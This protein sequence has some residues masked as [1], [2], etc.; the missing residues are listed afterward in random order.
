MAGGLAAL[1][2]RLPFL[3]RAY[4]RWKHHS[5]VAALDSLLARA[6]LKENANSTFPDR[7]L[8]GLS[9]ASQRMACLASYLSIIFSGKS[10]DRF[11]K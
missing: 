9:L 6:I 1:P 4:F 10:E 2:A 8:S 7:A 11:S 5:P 3:E